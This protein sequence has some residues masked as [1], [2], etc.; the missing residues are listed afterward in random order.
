ML[1]I[2]QNCEKRTSVKGGKGDK[3]DAVDPFPTGSVHNV[4]GANFASFCTLNL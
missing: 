3:K 1:H 4:L 2:L